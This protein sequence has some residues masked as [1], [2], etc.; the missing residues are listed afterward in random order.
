MTS[1]PMNP[2]DAAWY[3]MDGPANLAMV[4]GIMLTRQRLDFASV[5]ALYLDRMSGFQRFRQ[6]VVERGLPLPTPHWEEMENFDIDQ[7]LHHVALA[8]PQH[9]ADLLEV[10]NDIASAPLDREQ[11]LWQVH[12]VDQV[13]GGSALVMRYH[14]CIGDGTAMMGVMARLFDAS[15]LAP[16][17]PAAPSP[18]SAAA[19]PALLADAFGTVADSARQALG[20][21]RAALDAVLEPKALLAKAELVLAGAG[22]LVAELIKWPDPTSP[23]KGE[24]GLR[25][26]VAWSQPV[27]IHDV[28][29]IGAQHGAKVN[30]VLVAAMSGALR[31]YL[32]AR[33]VAV[34]HTT[35][36][37]M[38][39]V[40]LRPPERMGQLGNEF[41]LVILDLPVSQRGW[42][43]RL[44]AT[45]QRMDL[46]KRSPEAVAM[47]LLLDLFGRMP[48]AVEDL[49]NQVFGSKASVVMTN[50]AGPR[51]TVYLAGVA[52]ERMMFWV[53]HPGRQ[54]GMGISIFSY[55]GKATLSVIADA[56]LIPDPQTITHKFNREFAAMLRAARGAA[57]PKTN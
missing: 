36:R 24:F 40:D 11:P 27:S 13:G 43:Q 31:S 56:R 25:K 37:A 10:V 33:G 52:I 42:R 54:L 21:T 32:A 46:L 51:E 20:T 16:P 34:N 41:G 44:S 38:V 1:E 19:Q 17:Q 18:N 39:P 48:K 9:R 35:V 53:P 23:L 6:R 45:K 3:H 7:H 15:P 8:P 28:K 57:Q 29:A 30:D 12:V 55:R 5:R 2:V 49:A 14:H 26:H 50:V 4:T 47:K 22:M